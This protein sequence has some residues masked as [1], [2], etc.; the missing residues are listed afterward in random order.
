M[1][2]TLFDRSPGTELAQSD[3]QRKLPGSDITRVRRRLTMLGIAF[4]IGF[5]ALSAR[6]IHLSKPDLGSGMAAEAATVAVAP[7]LPAKWR[8]RSE[9]TDRDGQLLAVDLPTHALSIETRKVRKPDRLAWRLAAALGDTTPARVLERLEKTQGALWLRWRLTPDQVAAVMRVGDPAISLV[10]TV[11]RSYPNGRLTAHVVGFM[12]SERQG[13]AGLERGVEDQLLDPSNPPV[14]TSIHLGV[15]HAVRAE[16]AQAVRT[17]SAIGGAA[18]VMDVT[19][20]EILSMVSLPDFDANLRESLREDAFFNRATY[21]RYEMGSTFKTF[22]AAMALEAGKRLSDSY[23]AT[24]PIRFGRFRIRDHHARKREMTVAEIFKFSSNIG[25][26]KMAVDV[27]TDGQRKFLGSLGLLERLEIEIPE[28][29]SPQ[30]PYRWG[31]LET[32]TIGF[33]HGLSVSPL[34][35]ATAM[36]AMVNGGNLIEPTL[37]KRSL[38]NPATQR[39]VISGTT[40]DSIRKL[41]RLVVADG[42]G[43]SAAA[44]GYVVG[45]KTGTAEK[46]IEKGYARKRLITSFVGVF[47]MHAPRYVVLAMLDEPQGTK[48]TSN[49][50]T[51]G[52][53]AAPTVGRII[54]RVAP[55]LGVAPVDELDPEILHAL[56]LPPSADPFAKKAKGGRDATL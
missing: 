29:V 9:I 3:L 48:E 15:Q 5:T 16:L 6:V 21:G 28:L 33:G 55:L 49:Y 24:D 35:L 44:Q 45:G 14:E 47:P 1:N 8:T 25:A 11:T 2:R 46:A 10:P 26:A 50:M 30:L 19:N 17:F 22:T 23:D 40:S 54:R 18:L 42:T 53:N 51:A 34:H 52:W 43:R 31:E 20:G 56:A 32:M 4:A 7:E 27:G 41:L 38:D 39:R 12:D 13:R 36:G 37:L